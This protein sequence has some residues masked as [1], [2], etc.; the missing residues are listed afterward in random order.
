[1]ANEPGPLRNVPYMGVIYVVAEAAKLGYYGEHPDWCNLGQGMPEVGPLP[2]APERVSEISILPD[3]HAYGPVAGLSELR[4][5]V[6]TLYNRQFRQG[7]KSQY[8]AANVAITA[9]GRLALTRAVWALGQIRIGYFTPDYT[10]YEDL[11]GGIPR[12]TPVHIHLPAENG[13][14]IPVQQLEKEVLQS[15]LNALLIS[16]PCNPTGRV[17]R[18]NELQSWVALARQ[19]RTALILD[20]FYSHFIWNGPAPVSAAAFVEDVDKDPVMIIDGLTKNYRYPGWRVGWTLGPPDW[21]ETLTCSGSAIDGGAPRWLQRAA[22]PLVEPARARQETQ[23]MR[24]AFRL[25]RDFMLEHLK[26]M[27]VIL[28]RDP[29]GTFYCWGSVENLPL[30]LS[31]GFQFFR[32]A[33]KEKVITVPGEFFDVNPA[34]H[35]NDPPRLKSFVRFSFGAPMNIVQRG[36]ARLEAMTAGKSIRR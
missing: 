30:P 27:G 10:A 32:E 18:D 25:K 17:I 36:V 14:A 5:A 16:N 2:N 28:P 33:L 26:S 1:M 12:I 22:V 19:H 24:D 29:E 21:I 4:E 8:T 6:A 13:F 23:A 35:R 31:D 3:D 9:G 11:L 34:K 15:G 7:M 20:E